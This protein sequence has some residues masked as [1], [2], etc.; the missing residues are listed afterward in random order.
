VEA[1]HAVWHV[2]MFVIS[3]G[4]TAL[5]LGALETTKVPVI[6]VRF[7]NFSSQRLAAGHARCDTFL[8]YKTN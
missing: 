8:F 2:L 1:R 7:G 6:A 3:L 5:A 4:E